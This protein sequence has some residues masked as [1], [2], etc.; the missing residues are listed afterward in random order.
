MEQKNVEVMRKKTCRGDPREGGWKVPVR[1]VTSEEEK[2]KRTIT[3]YF[4]GLH[5]KKNKNYGG[6]VRKKGRN[7]SDPM[8]RT[9]GLKKLKGEFIGK[10][11]HRK[12]TRQ[13]KVRKPLEKRSKG[14]KNL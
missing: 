2:K 6:S 7:C 9:E 14:N 8:E 4:Q 13:S 5:E 1:R 3:G 11:L 10:K 12:G